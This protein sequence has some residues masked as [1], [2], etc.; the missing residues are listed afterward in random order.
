MDLFGTGTVF[1]KHLKVK[2]MFIKIAVYSY[3]SVNVEWANICY[4]QGEPI[5]T[6]ENSMSL[7]RNVSQR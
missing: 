2:S 3:S 1:I 5:E 7:S 4:M 6:K